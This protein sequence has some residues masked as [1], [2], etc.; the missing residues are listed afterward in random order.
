MNTKVTGLVTLV[1]GLSASGAGCVVAG[2]DA[3][4]TV[5]EAAEAQI[6]P[7][8]KDYVLYTLKEGEVFAGHVLVT[9]TAGLGFAADREYWF[10]TVNLAGAPQLTVNSAAAQYWSTPPPALGAP[11]F[12]TLRN[13]VWI[14][15]TP[16]V[17]VLNEIIAITGQRIGID[18]QMTNVGGVW[19][20]YIKW[21]NNTTGNIWG[22]S[23][24]NKL[25]LGRLPV[26]TWYSYTTSPLP[27]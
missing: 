13:P 15:D 18:W 21:W 8:N 24:G 4:A 12:V 17:G 3:E 22:P 27:L 9:R 1:V 25:I 2:D 11:S 26:G 16:T 10:M 20:G 19:S 14:A 6:D 23:M 5:G 7:G